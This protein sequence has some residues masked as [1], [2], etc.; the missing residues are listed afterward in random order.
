MGAHAG[1]AAPGPHPRQ[2]GWTRG[3]WVPL[4]LEHIA[5]AGGYVLLAWLGMFL[6]P[7]GRLM[8]VWPA[9]GFAL[10]MLLQ[11]GTSRWP[12]ILLG[13]LIGS[14]LFTPWG[15]VTGE[16]TAESSVQAYAAVLMSMTRTLATVA[17]VWL[18]RRFVGS[19]HWPHTVHEVLGFMIVAGFIHPAL[20]S[21]IP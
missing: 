4:L 17:G 16:A 10:A 19:T 1:S 2:S 9:G 15:W 12:A 13:A 11:R 21:V 7:K 18:I 5:I 14:Y 6:M 20:I 3:P 8:T